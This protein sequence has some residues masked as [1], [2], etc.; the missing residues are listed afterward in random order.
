MG[1]QFQNHK[2]RSRV[3]NIRVRRDGHE[4]RKIYDNMN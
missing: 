4:L 3:Q 1:M 2:H